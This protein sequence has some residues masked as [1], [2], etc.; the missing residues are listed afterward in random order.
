MG[1]GSE[2]ELVQFNRL[3]IHSTAANYV[4]FLNIN[5]RHQTSLKPSRLAL[6][7]TLPAL[8]NWYFCFINSLKIVKIMFYYDYYYIDIF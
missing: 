4:Y 1:N 2:P 7:V 6:Y 3:R 5:D 8:G